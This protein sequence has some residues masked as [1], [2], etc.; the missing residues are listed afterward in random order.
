MLADWTEGS[1]EIKQ[2]LESLES[3]SIPVLA[4]FPAAKPGALTPADYRCRRPGNSGSVAAREPSG[5]GA[6]AR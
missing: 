1:P 4:V 2:M 6:R 3:K 5:T